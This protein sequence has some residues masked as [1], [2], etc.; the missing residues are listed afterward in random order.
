MSVWDTKYCIKQWK[1]LNTSNRHMRELQKQLGTH[2]TE[3]TKY[4]RKWK[5]SRQSIV[6][7]SDI[8]LDTYLKNKYTDNQN[9]TIE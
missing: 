8:D 4:G 6:K 3:A 1:K 9:I 7:G 5:A 2:N